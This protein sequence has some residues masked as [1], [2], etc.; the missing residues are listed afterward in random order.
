LS[1][2]F[3]FLIFSSLFLIPKINIIFSSIFGFLMLCHY[4]PY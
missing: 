1:F 3:F 4:S 2:L